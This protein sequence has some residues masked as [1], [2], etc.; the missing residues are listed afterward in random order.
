M[1]SRYYLQNLDGAKRC[2]L[3]IT[4]SS[5][6]HGT[7]A[8][9]L[10]PSKGAAQMRPGSQFIANLDKTEGQLGKI[11][12]ISYRTPMDMI[13]VPPSSSIWDRAENLEFRVALHPLMLS[14]NDVL[15]DIER[16]L[17][18]PLDS[19]AAYDAGLPSSSTF[20]DATPRETKPRRSA[21]PTVTSMIRPRM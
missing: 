11:P 10:Y 6:H 8:A 12:V 5:P 4:I 7:K 21:T 3:F 2:D 18:L 16:H 9:W 14:S 1:V 17:M 13:I 19:R 20:T 15:S